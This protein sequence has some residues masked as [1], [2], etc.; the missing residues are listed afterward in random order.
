MKSLKM[1]LCS[2]IL[3]CSIQYLLGQSRWT[4]VYFPYEDTWGEY[5]IESY[6]KGYLLTGKHG[7]NYVHY[8]WLIKTDINGEILWEKTFGE[9]NSF[10]GLYF[11]DENDKGEIYLSGSTS[12]YDPYRDPIIMKLNACGEK[13]WCR[14]FNIPN[15][16]DYAHSIVATDD[17][18]CAVI[19]RY[20]G[21]APPQTDR[22][23][24]AKFD[25]DGN[26]QW[27]QCYNSLDTN[28]INEDSRSLLITQDKGFLITAGCDYLDTLV[29]NKYWIK[30]YIIKTDSLGNFQWETVVHSNDSSNVGGD[31]WTTTINPSGQFYYTSISHYYHDPTI[32]KPALVKLDL[33]GN[34]IAIYNIISGYENGGLA[35]AQFIN[36]SIM[37]ADCGWG[38]SMDEVIDYATLIDT[39]GNLVDTTQLIQDIYGSKLCIGYDQKLVYMYNTYQNDQF[40]VYLRKLN[41]NLEDDTIYTI[42]FTYDSLCPYQIVSDTIVQDDCGLIVGIEEPGS[43][44]AGKQGS[45]EAG[46]RG[47]LEVWPN[48]ARDQLH[49]RL[50]MDSLSAS[51]R[52]GRFNRDLSLVIYDIFGREIQ[53]IKIPD[54]QNE[55]QINVEG[56]PQGI[57]LAVVKDEN[58][59]VGS[60]KFVVA[61]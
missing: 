41:Y 57:Y 10:F 20:T 55:V 5:F 2:I 39:L 6:D 59:Y 58:Q 11:L 3:L 19:L 35:Y 24:L 13:I 9:P 42:P 27:K 32:N 33:N 21:V 61:R 7:H 51:W 18:G 48:P 1:F 34:V 60:A 28:L 22:I 4:N 45:R 47:I 31:A 23:C 25:S 29:T 50:S 14:V 37:A 36:D 43:G 17:G 12:Y 49:G 53:K 44:E 8:L 30:P 52:N 40:D 56:F 26:L 54:G 15:H 38:N 16:Y 46:K